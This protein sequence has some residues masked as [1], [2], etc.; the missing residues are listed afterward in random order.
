MAHDLQDKVCQWLLTDVAVPLLVTDTEGI[1]VLSNPGAQALFGYTREEFKGLS[2]ES[3]VPESYRVNH[4][5]DRTE[6]NNKPGKRLMKA[7]RALRAQRKDGSEFVAEIGLNPMP[8]GL[9]LATIQDVTERKRVEDSLR[10]RQARLERTEEIAHLG[11]WELDFAGNRLAWSDEVYRIFGLRPQEFG[12]TYAAFLERVHPDDRAAVDE[13]YSSSL[14]ENRDIYEIEHR[15]VRKD[16]GDIRF[17]HEKCQHFRDENGRIVRSVGMIHDITERRRAADALRES[18]ER[19]RLFIEHA[20]VALAVFDRRM[21]YLAVSLRWLED[22]SLDGRD[23]IGRS[24]YEIFPEI[25]DRWKTVHQRGLAGEVVEA[26]EDSFE[27]LDGSVQWLHW[28]VRP[29]YMADGTVG[30]IVIF[31]EDITERKHADK[32]LRES[33][34]RFRTTLDNMLEGCQVIGFDWR[35]RYLNNAVAAQTRQKKEAL[36]GRTM[37]EVYPGIE[38]TAMFAELKRCMDERTSA[39]LE[40]EFI[41]PDGSKSW[42]ELSMQPVP[43]G[44][45]ILSVDITERK[46]SEAALQAM[47][48]EMEQVTRFQVAGQT[49]SALAHE[50]NQPLNAV[51]SYAE[52]A[53]RLLRAGNPQ[54]D[55]LVHAIESSAAQAQRAGSVVRE[56]LAFVRQGEVQT[57]PVDINEL[58]RGVLDRVD[59]DGY[60]GFHTQL[61]LA[62]GLPHVRANRLQVEKVLAN[63]I[64][65]GVEAMHDAGIGTRSITL[66]VRTNADVGMAQVTVRDS[67]PG[68]DAETLHRIFDPFFT[69]KPGGLGMGLAIS[70]AIIESHGGQLW[71]ESEPGAGASFHLTLPFA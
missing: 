54:P 49:V 5:K 29:W 56:L 53:L 25:P 9:V 52:A 61:E 44:V 21:R 17:V 67:G 6:Y 38:Q 46:R 8:N 35:Y 1:I 32:A 70:R 4:R 68:I 16:S 62:P 28:A 64:R 42:F 3:L 15:I 69:T 7:G 51:T 59:K 50:L 47:R 12:A 20:P 18:E 36:L 24:H 55:K 43:E 31:A 30:G 10:E 60:G 19:L 45:F 22:Y 33:E 23:V 11:S 63:L 65:N 34:E 48:A 40:N 26:D 13:A 66:A 57:E 71:V 27:R 2:V 14:R 37:M 58:V 41:F 39:Y